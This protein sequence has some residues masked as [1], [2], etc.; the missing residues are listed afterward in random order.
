MKLQGVGLGQELF[1]QGDLASFEREEGGFVQGDGG[2]EFQARR[3]EHPVSGV[4]GHQSEARSFFLALRDRHAIRSV[5]Q[6]G[7]TPIR[8]F[9]CMSTLHLSYIY[10][11]SIQQRARLFILLEDYAFL[12]GGVSGFRSNHMA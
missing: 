6:G 1:G 2:F 7:A 4:H 12:S 9:S 5:I 3:E 11:A 10:R 8:I